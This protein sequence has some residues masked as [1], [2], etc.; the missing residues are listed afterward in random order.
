M[1][2]LETFT[3]TVDGQ[4]YE[5]WEEIRV[6]RE[7]DRMCTDFNIMV[8]E[9]F[10]ADTTDFPIAPF[11]PCTVAI[12]ADVVLTG[13]IDNYLPEV[14][15]DRH[16]VRITGRS[17]TEDIIDCTPDI[18]G[19]QFAGYKVDAIARAIGQSVGKPYPIAVVV[20]VDVGEAFPDATSE[21]HE[22]G[23]AFLE[24]LCRLRSVL[25]TDDEKGRLVLTRAAAKRATDAL[26][27]GP[28]GNV[29]WAAGVFSGARR[30]SHYKVKAQ[31]SVH[32]STSPSQSWRGVQPGSVN[33]ASADEGAE[34]EFADEGDAVAGDAQ[35]PV[36]T[37]VEGTATDPGVPRYRPHVMMGES[38]LDGPGAM[39][40]AVW[41]AKYTAARGT[42]ARIIVSGWRQSDGSLWRINHLVPVRIPFLSLDM[43]LLIAGVSHV[44]N[45]QRESLGPSLPANPRRSVLGVSADQVRG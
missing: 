4:R 34:D 14:E 3:L 15:A 43:E 27:Q 41:Q 21:R 22:T 31:Q 5:R 2:P 20:E 30:F 40:R 39:R 38:A 24:R 33:A 10:L 26:L 6:T 35:V 7:I 25:A 13:Y 18:Q 32:G 36:L 19:G 16:A 28:G 17:K 8:S 37:E 1:H 42:Q 45:S 12:G 9:R 23:F 29:Q 44:L 11:M